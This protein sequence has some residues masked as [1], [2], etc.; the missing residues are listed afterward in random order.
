MKKRIIGL[1]YGSK[2]VGV[3]VSDPLGFTAQGLETITRKDENKLRKTYARI[4]ALIREYEAEQIVLGYPKN[5]NDTEGERV[6]KTLAFKEALERRTGL[7][8]ILWDERMSTVASER[9]LME[10]NVRRE[11]R[12]TYIDKMAA[13][14]ILQGLS[15]LFGESGR[16]RRFGRY[17]V[18]VGFMHVCNMGRV[19][20]WQ[21][22][23]LH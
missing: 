1:D 12:K 19:E 5:M 10:G 11:D 16:I 9:V 2:T 7:E 4:E 21:Q 3:A 22:K 15:E 6:E 20:T 13:A 17:I 23:Q 18:I 14:F 8:V